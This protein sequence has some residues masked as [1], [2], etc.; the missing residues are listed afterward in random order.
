MIPREQPRIGLPGF[1]VH[2]VNNIVTIPFREACQL[3]QK[4]RKRLQIKVE[5][6]KS[7]IESAYEA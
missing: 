3:D 1:T 4:K 5:S 7:K 6:S 2:T